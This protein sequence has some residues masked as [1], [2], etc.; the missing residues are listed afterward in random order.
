MTT[1]KQAIHDL[2][3]VLRSYGEMYI[4][5]HPPTKIA[6]EW[7]EEGV[8]DADECGAWCAVYVW[9]PAVAGALRNAGITPQ[10]LADIEATMIKS[11]NDPYDTWTDG[12]PVYA[13]CND[14]LSVDDIIEAEEKIA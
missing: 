9:N 10:R 12:S 7:Y 13:I 3:V 5:G 1:K 11:V 2:A 8:T 4:G 6:E 14:D